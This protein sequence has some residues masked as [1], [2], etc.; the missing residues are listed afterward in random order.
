MRISITYNVSLMKMEFLGKVPIDLSEDSLPQT[1]NA[2]KTLLLPAATA[3]LKATLGVSHSV[4][5]LDILH[6]GKEIT[7]EAEWQEVLKTAL[8]CNTAAK[9]HFF[10]ASDEPSFE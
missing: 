2:A 3:H 5:K 6:E 7:S 1:L 4:D 8:V 10:Y 9:N